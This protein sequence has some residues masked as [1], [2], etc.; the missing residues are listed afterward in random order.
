MSNNIVFVD[1]KNKTIKEQYKQYA[2]VDAVT[3]TGH[4][5][6]SRK[7]DNVV[8][9]EVPLFVQNSKD[10]LMQVKVMFDVTELNALVNEINNLVE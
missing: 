10:R 8:H 7:S 2:W 3:G 9:V 1:F 6:D 4:M 5:F